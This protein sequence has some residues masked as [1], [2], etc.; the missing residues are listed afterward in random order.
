[1]QVFEV[2]CNWKAFLDVFNEY[3]HLNNVHPTSIDNL[4]NIPEEADKTTGD[5]ASQ[6]GLT[7]GTGA[8]LES[9]QLSALPKMANLD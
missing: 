8:F 3:Y 1:M 6:F 7:S 5:Y 4:Y 2:Q 9:Q